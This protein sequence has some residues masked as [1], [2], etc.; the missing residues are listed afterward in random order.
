[1]GDR[2]EIF[3]IGSNAER[4]SEN[5]PTVRS[6]RECSFGIRIQGYEQGPDCRQGFEADDRVEKHRANPQRCQVEL[7]Y[8]LE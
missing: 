3:A 2:E 5:Y 4:W 7:Q 8:T 1:M 6:V